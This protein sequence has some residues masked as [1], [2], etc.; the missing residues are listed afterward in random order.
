MPQRMPTKKRDEMRS[1]K[2]AV[3]RAK[4]RQSRDCDLTTAIV[5][6]GDDTQIVAALSRGLM[7]LDA[8]RRTDVGL[9]NA[10]LAERTGLTK[11]TVSRLTYTLSRHNYLQFDVHRREY[12]LGVGAITLGAVALAMTNVRNI[13]LPLMRELAVGSRFNVGLGT[14]AGKQMVYTDA[15]EG[16]ALISLRLLPGSRI[17]I[18]TSAMG[19]AY[20]AFLEPDE[21]A[22]VLADVRS[23]YD[24]DWPTVLHG[25][26]A[27]IADFGQNGFCCSI[28]EWHKDINGVA[29]PI[30]AA[31]GEPIH[32]LNL[33]G[34]AYALSEQELRENL[35]P[36]LIEAVR[37][38]EAALGLGSPV[39]NDPADI[40]IVGDTIV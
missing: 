28:G 35:G 29:V 18:A 11:P 2:D 6:D 16:D 22:A 3:P 8:F 25:V 40:P 31:S 32:V 4:H 33:G 19:R 39:G 10:E 26:D 27:A 5:E 20:L 15:C 9:G 34:P 17:P 13:A 14:R 30:R 36:R 21:R 37:K 12:R 7:L 23:R 1:E 38:I 24:D